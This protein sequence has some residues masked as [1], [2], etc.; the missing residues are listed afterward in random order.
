[1]L[2]SISRNEVIA[3]CIKPVCIY[4]SI[5]RNPFKRMKMHHQN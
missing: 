2:I 5:F 1:M 4:T 3:M